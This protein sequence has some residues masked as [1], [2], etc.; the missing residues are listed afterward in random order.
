MNAVGGAER[1]DFRWILLA[2]GFAIGLIVAA[3]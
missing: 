2:S 1:R 3:T